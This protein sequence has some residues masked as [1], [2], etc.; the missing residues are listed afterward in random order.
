MF[1]NIIKA[2]KLKRI[3]TAVINHGIWPTE[4]KLIHQLSSERIINTISVN[5]LGSIW[6]FQEFFKQLK[7]AGPRKDGIGASACIIGSTAGIVGQAYHSDYSC[8][9]AGLFGLT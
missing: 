5:L 9:K 2:G 8:S 4:D 6:I 3:D 7:S 1:E